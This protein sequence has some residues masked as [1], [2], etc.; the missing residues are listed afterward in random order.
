LRH[1]GRS[2]AAL[3]WV[4]QSD[5]GSKDSRA[6]L[7]AVASGSRW[8]GA[9]PHHSLRRFLWRFRAHVAVRRIHHWP[10]HWT[11][12]DEELTVLVDVRQLAAASGAD[13]AVI[14]Q[15][16]A[17]PP[18]RAASRVPARV[19]N[20]GKGQAEPVAE[21]SPSFVHG[22]LP[23]RAYVPQPCRSNGCLETI[24]RPLDDS[25]TH[26]I[27]ELKVVGRQAPNE[28]TRHKSQ[29]AEITARRSRAEISLRLRQT[30]VGAR[31]DF[32]LTRVPAQDA[33]GTNCY[34][35]PRRAIA[36]TATATFRGRTTTWGNG[37]RTGERRGSPALGVPALL[38]VT[39]SFRPGPPRGSE[40]GKKSH[41][42]PFRNAVMDSGRGN[43]ESRPFS[44]VPALSP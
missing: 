1:S 40:F 16:A 33:F 8:S 21:W 39:S 2:S 23:D 25:Q 5:H 14:A 28:E 11:S 18:L 35:S 13:Q 34:R 17:P 43:A 32:C 31:G 12:I 42:A 20:L 44:G 24:K 36:E 30:F 26:Q 7:V 29:R 41:R 38:A 37:L 3:E 9:A 10:V 15:H 19:A 6:S 22:L 27:D 4:N